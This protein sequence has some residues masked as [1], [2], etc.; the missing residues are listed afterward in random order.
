MPIMPF[1]DTRP[2][3]YIDDHHHELPHQNKNEATHIDLCVCQKNKLRL[4]STQRR[5]EG[6][7]RVDREL[8]RNLK[9]TF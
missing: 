6:H 3:E 7:E 1:Q 5:G 8:R 4:L 9:G 2:Q